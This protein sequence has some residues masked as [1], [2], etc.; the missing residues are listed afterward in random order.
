MIS[1]L[2]LLDAHVVAGGK[3]Y[4]STPEVDQISSSAFYGCTSLVS[5]SLPKSVKD[6]D[7]AAFA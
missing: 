7:Y 4:Y 5:V 3:C 1:S 6:I 2:D